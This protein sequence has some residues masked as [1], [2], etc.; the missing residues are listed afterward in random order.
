MAYMR[1]YKGARLDAVNPARDLPKLIF[2]YH[3]DDLAGAQ[4][5]A[6]TTW[7]DRS[8]FGRY[9]IQQDPTRR[10]T[11]HFRADGRKV[12]RFAA[13]AV[14]YLFNPDVGAAGNGEPSAGYAQPNTYVFVIKIDPAQD[15]VRRI[16]GTG[17]TSVNTTSIEGAGQ[18]VKILAN[19]AWAEGGARLDDGQWHII[20][21]VF[22][23]TYGQVYVDGY[24]VSNK[25]TADQGTNPL[26]GFAIGATTA[27]IYPINGADYGQVI[28]VNAAL[29]PQQILDLTEKLAA[30][31]DI[32]ITPPSKQGNVV[33]RTATD[34]GGQAIKY[35]LPDNVKPSGN[36]LVIWS[37]QHTGTEAIVPSTL[38]TY[39]LIHSCANE[40]WIVAASRMHGDNWG[41]A[42]AITDLTNL[43]SY[44]NGLWGIS[45]V[46]LVGGS[47]GGL[48]T[49]LAIPY[50][51]VPNIKACITVD[52]VLNLAN[53]HAA[54]SYTSTVR[55]AYGV[56]ADGSDY[57]TKT[58][59]HDPMLRPA[60]DFG[61]VPWM[62]NL[63]DADTAVVPSANG[64]AFATKI[65]ATAS[66]VMVV[67]HEGGH[68][69]STGV[70]PDK[71]IA[72]I[73]RNL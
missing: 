12:A 29:T 42:D 63:T 44:I 62:I 13:G 16:I 7:P 43:Y 33:T 45:K 8:G 39:P 19:T 14:R 20:T 11:V 24:L 68:L 69:A 50:A 17:N 52:G 3:A 67:R 53:M 66:E 5:D 6:I 56:A 9:L 49:A 41:N 36:T 35:W 26:S 60:A 27:A 18:A 58:A 23:A 2:D 21:S 47:M 73:K 59:G 46:I 51:A 15:T 37:H 28:G 61:S 22:G 48:A 57:A 70:H 71:I 38:P 10:P 65:A 1:D 55:T 34:S 32:D 30:E 4:G 25:S 54:P 40:G 72:F 31:W 64:D